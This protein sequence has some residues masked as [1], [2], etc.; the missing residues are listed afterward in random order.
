MK[1]KTFITSLACVALAGAFAFGASGCAKPGPAAGLMA[2]YG[3][4]DFVSAER[5]SKLD[6]YTASRIDDGGIIVAQKTEQASG[7]QGTAY[8][9]ALYDIATDTLVTSTDSKFNTPEGYD[10]KG[11]YYTQTSVTSGEYPDITVSYTYTFYNGTEKGQTITQDESIMFD[12]DGIARLA[13]GKVIY[14]GVDGEVYYGEPSVRPVATLANAVR[15]GD[16]YIVISNELFFGIFDLNGNYV[17]AT[18]LYGALANIQLDISDAEAYWQVGNRLFMQGSLA[19]PDDVSD[20]DYFQ[21]GTKYDLKTYYFDVISG[22]WGEIGDFN[23]VVMSGAD[24]QSADLGSLNPNAY[25][26]LAVQKILDGKTLSSIPYMQTY[27]ADGKVYTDVQG[28]LSGAIMVMP[29]EDFFLVTNGTEAVYFDKN[30]NRIASLNPFTKVEWFGEGYFIDAA[31]EK[32][33]DADFNTFYEAPENST[34]IRVTGNK[35]YYSTLSESADAAVTR[36]YFVYDKATSTATELALF[37]GDSISA[38]DTFYKVKEG[39]TAFSVKDYYGNTIASDVAVPESGALSVSTA[40][41]VSNE[42]GVLYAVTV[43]AGDTAQTYFVKYALNGSI[44]NYS[45]IDMSDLI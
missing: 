39:D 20:Y 1:R 19:L 41:N 2:P 43:S 28:L 6:G 18:S 35:I 10:G 29:E 5:I 27:G 31:E 38:S 3:K 21:N 33:Y 7:G 26:L 24:Q 32:L 37:D 14:K 40:Y 12:D 25:A 36:K 22:E 34:I 17:R 30:G 13:D 16:N 42:N 15:M 45:A 9:Y 4:G 11:F 44:P 8:T 23:V